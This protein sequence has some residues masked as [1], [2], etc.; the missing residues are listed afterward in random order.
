MQP[1]RIGAGPAGHPAERAHPG[2]LLDRLDAEPDMLALDL[3]GHH[4]VIEPAIAVAD[5]LVPVGDK[6]ADQF[7]VALGR[8][9]HGQQAQLDAE[10][11]EQTQQAPAA[12]PRTVFEDGFDER[13]AQTRQRGLA[14]IVQRAL[15]FRVALQD[16][17]LAAALEVEIDVDRDTRPAWPLRIGRVSAVADEIAIAGHPDLPMPATQR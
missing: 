11:A 8:L 14:D 2:D 12:D 1:P 9:G 4:L 7:R 5:D 17:A 16:R 10:P 13:A 15:G 3:L 6:G